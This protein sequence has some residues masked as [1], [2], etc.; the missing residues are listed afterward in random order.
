MNKLR[1]AALGAIV[2]LVAA[3]SSSGGTA[4]ASADGSGGELQ[5]T[6]WILES[7]ATQ[8]ALTIVPDGLYADAEFTA[9]RVKGFSGCNDY[10]ALYRANGAVL[11]TSMAAVTLR[12]CDDTTAAFES[13]YMGHLLDSRF[14]NVQRNTLT[15]R[16]PDRSVLLVFDAAPA[17]PL[18]GSWLVDSYATA[19]GSVS[20]VLPGS[21]L[22]AVFRL[23]SVA[24][25][26]G[27]NTYDGRY[28]TNGNVVAITQLATTRLACPEPVM[29]QETAFLAA[30]QG[31]ARIETRGPT[32][33][34]ED[35][36]G[37]ISVALVRPSSV[38]PSPSAGPSALPSPSPSAS[39]AA[40]PS[41]PASAT[42]S[43]PSAP[44]P[45]PTAVPTPSA[46]P[47]GS[48]APTLPPPASVP[49]M[50]SCAVIAPSGATVAMMRYLSTWHTTD[51]PASVACRYFDPN[52]ITVPADPTTLS[53]AVMVKA[54]SSAAYADALATAT[55]ATAWTV[56]RNEPVTIGGLPAVRLET[57]AI[58]ASAGIPLGSTRYAYLIDAGGHPIWILTV[59]TA[60]D[61]AYTANVAVVNLMT[62]VSSVTVPPPS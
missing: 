60:G 44:T 15:I 48:P 30:L 16:G 26:S 20:A 7:Y 62:A 29:G 5:A 33:L 55:D 3:C 11:L 27:C 47:S 41:A 14:Y 18:L 2:L 40:S 22:T 36:N 1:L 13:T 49:P 53:T 35:R 51:T 52:P 25:S 45:N 6:T 59:G 12:A 28:T 39:P 34:L 32:L 10:D 23:R 54:D 46:V 21:T 9:N 4:D 31:V 38:E 8:G 17:N 24:G 42:P 56:L 61:P 37:G 58:S 57:T 19:P 43:P 50:S